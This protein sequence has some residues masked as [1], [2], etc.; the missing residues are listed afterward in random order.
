M[1]AFF[2]GTRVSYPFNVFF[3]KEMG[4]SLD[5]IGKLTAVTTLVRISIY[6]LVL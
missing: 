3:L 6:V 4:L 2:A 5:D 1:Q